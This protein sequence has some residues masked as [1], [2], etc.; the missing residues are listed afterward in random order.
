MLLRDLRELRD[1]DA[2][3]DQRIGPQR[4]GARVRLAVGRHRDLVHARRHATRAATT[5]ASAAT[6]TAPAAAATACGNR[7][8][9]RETRA[10]KSAATGT[11]ATESTTSAAWAWRK[12]AAAW[13]PRWTIFTRAR[14]AYRERTSLE[15]L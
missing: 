15:R 10:A 12:S 1:L 7:R 13:W 3:L 11:R 14:L 9:R 8:R 2:L 4:N 6:T 5:A